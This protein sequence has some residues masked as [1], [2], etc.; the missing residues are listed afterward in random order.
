MNTAATQLDFALAHLG[1][2]EYDL[3]K[4]NDPNLNYISETIVRLR[5][6]KDE[7]SHVSKTSRKNA[8]TKR[9]LAK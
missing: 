4:S 2:V 8:C 5:R 6:L 9:R 3:E 1:V 7:L